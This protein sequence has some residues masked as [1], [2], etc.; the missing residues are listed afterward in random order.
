[1]SMGLLLHRH[2]RARYWIELIKEILFAAVGELD[3]FR[4][5]GSPDVYRLFAFDEGIDGLVTP[6]EEFA[7]VEIDFAGVECA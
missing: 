1:M 7:F 4:L 2:R 5:S 6:Y 3:G